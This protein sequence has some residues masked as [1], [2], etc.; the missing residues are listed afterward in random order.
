MSVAARATWQVPLR[1]PPALAPGARFAAIAPAS[2]FDVQAFH[3][4]LSELAA[5]GFETTYDESV[6]A[7]DGYVAGRAADRAQALERAWRDPSIDA[8]VAVRG[9]YGSVHL[10]PLLDP[11]LPGRHPKPLVGYS[12]I[13]T[14]HMWQAQHG[15]VAFQGPMLEGRFAHGAD[16]YDRET[17]LRALMSVDPLGELRGPDLETFVEGEARGPIFGGTLTQVAASLGTPFAFDPPPA[18]ILF[19]EDVGERPYRLD[20]LL[21]QLRLA[22]ILARAAGI[23]L[24]TFPGCDEPGGEPT[25]RATLASLLRDFEGPVVFGLPVGHVEGPAL[26]LPLGVTVRLVANADP[27]VVVEEAAVA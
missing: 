24:G 27:R 26:T 7:R 20:R 19:L 10:L 16:R 2:A 13:T 23:V 6:F 9:G 5:L 17:F 12:D 25:G 21:M 18:C 1:K 14:L 4:G 22:G 8:I 15:Q 3:A 11:D